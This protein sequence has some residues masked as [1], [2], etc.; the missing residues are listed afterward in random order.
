MRL[1]VVASD[2]VEAEVW[3]KALYLSGEED[4]VR[5]ADEL[6]LPCVLVTVDGRTRFAGGL[7]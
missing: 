5:E 7:R 1:T 3:A 4:A 6:G 2:A